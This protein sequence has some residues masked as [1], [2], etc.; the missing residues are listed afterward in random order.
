M[1]ISLDSNL[2]GLDAFLKSYPKEVA[3]ATKRSMARMVTSMTKESRNSIKSGHYKTS[4]REINERTRK[5]KRLKGPV[6]NRL[7]AGLAY[8]DKPLDLIKF[9]KGKKSPRKQKGIK[10]SRR[11][12]IKAEVRPGNVSTLRR[13]FIAKGRGGNF[14]AFR[15]HGKK[16]AKQ[17]VPGLSHKIIS[18]LRLRTAVD[19]AARRRLAREM[20]INLRFFIGQSIIKNETKRSA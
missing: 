9:V 19:R 5:I 14:Q 16:L 6:F 13:T 10:V 8:S 1:N 4:N 15:R 2:E 3:K 17:V 7:E 18:S 11:R 20:P 12:P